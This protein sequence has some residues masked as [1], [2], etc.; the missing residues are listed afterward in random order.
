MEPVGDA[1][2]PVATATC[3]TKA[4]FAAVTL[5][6]VASTVLRNVRADAAERE[7]TE[8]LAGIAGVRGIDIAIEDGSITATVDVSADENTVKAVLHRYTIPVKV[9]VAP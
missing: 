6:A 7:L 9:H 2:P 5:A 1:V 4:V 3:A 8:A